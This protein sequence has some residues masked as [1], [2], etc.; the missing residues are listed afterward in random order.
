MRPSLLS[1]RAAGE[2]RSPNNNLAT[3]I[4]SL[5]EIAIKVATGKLPLVGSSIQPLVDEIR[6][7]GIVIL[8]IS[9]PHLYRMHRLERIHSDPFDRMI[10][11]QALEEE[12]VVVT[13][14]PFFAQYGVDVL[15]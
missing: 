8:P 1:S 14:D 15:W 12:L 3:S 7:Q 11:A 4:A 5:W 9:L 10:I 2:I 6:A 13:S